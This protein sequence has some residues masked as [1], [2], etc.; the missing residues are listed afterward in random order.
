MICP[1]FLRRPVGR[2]DT[3]LLGVLRLQPLP[4]ELHGLG[5]DDASNRLTREEPLQDVEADVPPGRTHCDKAAAN[6]GPQRQAR[7]AT[8]VFEFPLSIEAT[9]LYASNMGSSAR[10]TV[11][12]VTCNLRARTVVNFTLVPTMPGLRSASKGAYSRRCAGSVSACRTFSANG[13]V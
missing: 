3:E 9:Q 10:V 8:Q 5:A 2:L 11:V 4:A 6:V 1:P 12:G 13:A 7:A